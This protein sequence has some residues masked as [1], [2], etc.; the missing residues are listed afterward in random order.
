[1]SGSSGLVVT[2]TMSPPTLDIFF[3]YISNVF[4]FPGLPF[5]S[6]LSHPPPCLYEGAPH[7]LTHSYLPIVAFPY[8]GA[9]NTLKSKGLSFH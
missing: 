2:L 3:I 4:L 1:M 8:I 9:S 6:P 5:G 7:P